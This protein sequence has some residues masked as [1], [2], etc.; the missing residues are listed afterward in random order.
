MGILH[1][2]H[3]F[4]KRI[5][6]NKAEIDVCYSTPI[7]PDFLAQSEETFNTNGNKVPRFPRQL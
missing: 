6:D 4:V 5:T 2:T 3:V 1:I 7:P